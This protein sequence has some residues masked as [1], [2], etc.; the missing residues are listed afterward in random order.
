MNFKYWFRLPFLSSISI[1]GIF[2]S[3][4]FLLILGTGCSRSPWIKSDG[5]E[6]SSEEQIEC[7]TLVHRATPAESLNQEALQRRIEQCLLDKGYRRRPWW[8]LND[9]HWHIK[10]PSL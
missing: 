3:I 10:E 8:L 5:G 2:G 4:L 1:P 9:L 6:V 7:V